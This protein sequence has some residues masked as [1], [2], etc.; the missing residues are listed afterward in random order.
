MPFTTTSEIVRTTSTL[1]TVPPQNSAVIKPKE[2]IKPTPVLV[3]PLTIQP[4]SPQPPKETIVEIPINLRSIVVLRCLYKDSYGNQKKVFGSGVIISPEGLVLTARHVVDQEYTLAVTGGQ[5]G[6]SGYILDHCD[7]GQAPSG[8]KA[9][10]AEEIRKINPFYIIDVLPFV[11]QVQ[12]LPN[13]TDWSDNEKELFDIAVLRITGTNQDAQYFD[14]TMPNSFEYS[15]W[16][17]DK[18]PGRGDEVITFGF[19][20]GDP[21]YGS[22]FKIQGSV[23]QVKDLIGSN[24]V[25]ANQLLEI[26]A[27][28]ETIGGRSGSPLFW[29]GYVVGIISSKEDYSINSFATSILPLL[30]LR[31]L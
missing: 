14:V 30:K 29:K 13:T 12:F 4:P 9:P 19:P 31:P 26:A 15:R 18:F 7:V 10:T 28:M 3:A 17:G 6:F 20:S 11:A 24:Q 2:T 5:Q 25:F 27:T 23:G 1:T 22:R 21:E 8:S 16:L